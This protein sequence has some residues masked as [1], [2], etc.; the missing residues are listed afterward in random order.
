[1]FFVDTGLLASQ[2]EHGTAA[3]ILSGDPSAY[4][5]AMA[6]NMVAVAFAN[7]GRSLYY[8]HASSGSPNLDFVA[9]LLGEPTIV[10]CKSNNGRATS[11]KYALANAK[12]YGVHPAVKFADTNVGGGKGFVTLPLYALGFLPAPEEPLMVPEVSI[13][14]SGEG[15]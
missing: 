15:V 9:N 10:E 14:L 13:E 3:R 1:M 6:E 11:M 12:R 4:K 2:L 7:D 5:G 8:F